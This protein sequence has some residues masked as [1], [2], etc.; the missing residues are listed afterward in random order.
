M[1]VVVA[2]FMAPSGLK[3]L[4]DGVSVQY[5]PSLGAER[6][7]LLE[8]L[9]GAAG[10]VVRNR[11]RVDSELV[12]HAPRLAVVGRLGT[13]LDNV[14][15]PALEAAGVQLVHAAGENA[16]S[17][18]EFALLLSLALARR[19][20]AVWL[21]MPGPA[22]ARRH[23]YS[24]FELCG[25]RLGVVGFGAV[26]SALTVRAQA[27]GMTVLASGTERTRADAERLG[28]PMFGLEDLL[29]QVDIVSLHCPLTPVTHHLLGAAALARLPRGALVVNTA[30]GGLVDE[31]ALAAA[32]RSGHLGGA[33]L[34]VREVEPPQDPDPLRG[35]PGLILTPHVAGLTEQAQDRIAARVAAGVLRALQGGPEPRRP[36][37]GG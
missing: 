21:D 24:G 11:C 17:A 4:A 33:A 20:E 15:L 28:V 1:R 8:A 25:R 26:G 36:V 6:T 19:I 22:W 27:L 31:A 30:R 3:I 5:D 2:E 37:R 32:L 34:D 29:P 18:A 12:A 9:E 7:L 35:V 10:L 16:S 14:D 23:Q 13:G